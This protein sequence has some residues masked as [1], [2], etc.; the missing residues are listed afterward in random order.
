LL[1]IPFAQRVDH[2]KKR[3]LRLGFVVGASDQPPM[4]A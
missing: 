3:T 1:K 4:S 2:S